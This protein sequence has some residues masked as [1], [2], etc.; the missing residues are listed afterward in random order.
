M[1]RSCNPVLPPFMEEVPDPQCLNGNW[2][3]HS[4]TLGVA[5]VYGLISTMNFVILLFLASINKPLLEILISLEWGVKVILALTGTYEVILFSLF[6]Q[7]EVSKEKKMTRRCLQFLNIAFHVLSFNFGAAYLPNEGE[8]ML[9]FMQPFA[10]AFY[11][12]L[13]VMFR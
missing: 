2:S 9:N 8:I 6:L 3:N 13:A 12:L 4:E 7:S 1:G 10:L 11:G 5:I